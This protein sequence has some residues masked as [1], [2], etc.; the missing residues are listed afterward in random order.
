MKHL[1][2]RIHY[3]LHEIDCSC[4]HIGIQYCIF[5]MISYIHCMQT[6]RPL[7]LW[8]RLSKPLV[9]IVLIL[10]CFYSMILLRAHTDLIPGIQL[11]IPPI[12]VMETM[13]FA[14]LSAWLFIV[15]GAA[16]WIYNLFRPVDHYRRKFMG[17]WWM[18]IMIIGFVAFMWFG[19]V[20]PNGIS[21]FVLVFG[22]VLFF[23]W[24]TI[25]D[26]ILNFIAEQQERKHPYTVIMYGTDSLLTAT[27]Q[28]QLESYKK[29]KVDVLDIAKASV[30]PPAYDIVVIAWK[31]SLSILQHIADCARIQGQSI[32]H[33]GDELFLE[34]L[35]TTPKRL[36][37]C[38]A[39][40]YTA[41]PLHG[42]WRVIKRVMDVLW[43]AG[44]LLV[45][46]PLLA[47]I[48]LAIKL[49]SDWPV[50][51]TQDRVGKN[52]GLFTFMKFRSMYTH[53]SVW[54][55]YGWSSAKDMYEEL[56]HSDKNIR[57]EILPKIQDDPRITRVGKWLRK[58]SLDELPSL[59]NVLLWYMSLVWPRPHMPRE[60]D[61][62][63]ARQERLFSI[64]PGITGY[65]QIFWRDTLP[66]EEEARFDLYYI[67][68]WSIVLDIFVLLS[69]IKVVFSGR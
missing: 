27:I 7:L 33:I 19:Y 3:L 69:T 5:Y 61:R 60:V 4:E 38:L 40:A 51:Y 55:A 43:S 36:W 24:W 65:A 42:R 25:L 9:H 11:R 53:M 63:D 31:A 10:V 2:I 20:F 29:Y 59:I 39:L 67:Q 68:H 13:M 16:Q 21:R 8:I 56:I 22:A 48:A 41:S 64:K 14:W 23:I 52:K 12:D 54:D 35:I 17:V 45:L 6:K 15:I 37:P 50:L 62:Y 44:W 32:Y 18:W 26:S 1:Y 28:Q 46:S 49:D 57:D 66:F 58:T 30:I 34:D 47:L